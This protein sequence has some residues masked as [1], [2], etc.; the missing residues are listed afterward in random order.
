MAGED[1]SLYALMES[2]FP[3]DRN[4]I[5]MELPDRG[6]SAWSF[7][8]PSSSTSVPGSSTPSG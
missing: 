2:N 8:A 4:R 5:A 7:D 3:V 1:A 6:G